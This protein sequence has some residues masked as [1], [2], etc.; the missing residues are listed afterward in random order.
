[1][2]PNA[3][4]YGKRSI[5]ARRTLRTVLSARGREDTA[6]LPPCFSKTGDAATAS[7]ASLESNRS[8]RAR[9]LCGEAVQRGNDDT[10][11]DGV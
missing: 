5:P 11:I 1:M 9:C 3:R 7:L 10:G 8:V 6:V 4:K 2:Y